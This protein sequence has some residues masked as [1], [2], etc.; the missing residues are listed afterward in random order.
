MRLQQQMESE[1]LRNI[2]NDKEKERLNNLSLLKARK[3]NY[4]LSRENWELSQQNS[5]AVRMQF[6]KGYIQQSDLLNERLKTDQSRQA[7][8]QSAY[9]LFNTLTSFN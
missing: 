9:D 2:R 3:E 1:N 6:E 4:L 5:V 8:L 7:F